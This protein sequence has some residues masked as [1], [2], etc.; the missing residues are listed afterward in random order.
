MATFLTRSAIVF[1]AVLA[2]A[3]F[4]VFVGDVVFFDV[5]TNT[6]LEK[7]KGKLSGAIVLASP[8]RELRTPFE[9]LAS[10]LEETNLL[11]LANAGRAWT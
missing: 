2:S 8:L 5:K 6:D 11:R 7:Y 1:V 4:G 10:R 3:M 9:P